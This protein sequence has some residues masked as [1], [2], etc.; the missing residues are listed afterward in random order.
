MAMKDGWSILP[1]DKV[2]SIVS[3]NRPQGGVGQ[4]KEGALSLGGEHI[5]VD[6][7]LALSTPKFVPLDYYV[8]NPKG[9]IKQGDILLCKDGALSGK[10]ALERGELDGKK[11]MVN[12]HVFII[13]TDRI[14]QRYLFFY[15]FSPVGQNLLKGIVTGAAQGGINGKNLKSLPVVF[16]NSVDEQ[17]HIVDELDLLSGIIEKKNCQLKDLDALSRSVFYEMF[18]EPGSNGQW[19]EKTVGDCFIS[20]KNGANIKQTKGAKGLPITRIETLA[21]GVFNRDRLGY[22]DVYDVEKYHSYILSDGD[23]LMSHINSKAYIGRSVVY[24]ACPDETIIHGMNL[25]RLIANDSIILPVYAKFFFDTEYFKSQVASI[26]K[27]AVNQSSMAV[28]DLKKL[29][30]LTPSLDL[31][32]SFIERVSAIEEQKAIIESS[33]KDSMTLLTS[34]MD[35]WFC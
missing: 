1:F 25:L 18:G 26:R 3:G 22:A 9:H 6:G 29:K 16:P 10:V 19:K 27:D 23:I 14:D 20:I 33:V 34:R 8:A 4:Y 24:K 31:Q 21:N 35:Y 11:S 30:I 17:R 28:G 13:R 7:K 2:G 12:E 5:G 15:L 32:E